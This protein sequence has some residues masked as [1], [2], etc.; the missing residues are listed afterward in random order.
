MD[1]LWFL[2]LVMGFAFVLGAFA[3]W[4]FMHKRGVV[5]IV[6][7]VE[8]P[9]ADVDFDV[10]AQSR[11]VNPY[12]THSPLHLPGMHKCK[13]HRRSD[14]FLP[15]GCESYCAQNVCRHCHLTFA[16]WCGGGVCVSGGVQEGYSYINTRSTTKRPLMV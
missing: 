7:H 12:Y 6:S 10:E 5:T 11:G 16:V 15:V 13:M 3:M 8:V 2:G 4:L 9:A 1:F 14:G